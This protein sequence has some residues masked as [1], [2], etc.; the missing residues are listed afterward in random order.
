MEF[1]MWN[2]NSLS[3]WEKHKLK[4]LLMSLSKPIMIEIIETWSLDEPIKNFNYSSHSRGTALFWDTTQI[5]NIFTTNSNIGLFSSGEFLELSSNK[6]FRLTAIYPPSVDYVELVK[7]LQTEIPTHINHY[8]AGDFNIEHVS[9]KQK[10]K[11]IKELSKTLH[12]KES[13][14]SN[15]THIFKHRA[16][17]HLSLIDRLFVLPALME[18]TSPVSVKHT[19]FLVSD[20]LNLKKEFQNYLSSLDPVQSHQTPR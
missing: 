3:D 1:V 5:S 19:D 2:V 14:L 7:Y 8:L 9:S 20:H 17:N 13:F 16:N 4:A 10:I 12:V 6:K 11:V 18:C 15:F